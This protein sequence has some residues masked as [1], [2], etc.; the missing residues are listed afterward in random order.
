MSGVVASTAEHHRALTP[1]VAP[2]CEPQAQMQAWD[3]RGPWTP[4]GFVQRRIYSLSTWIYFLPHLRDRV[5]GVNPSK[6]KASWSCTILCFTARAITSH[7]EI[8]PWHCTASQSALAL[9]CTESEDNAWK[10]NHMEL[11]QPPYSFAVV[12]DIRKIKFPG[13]TKED[14]SFD[15]VVH[16]HLPW[17]DMSL[18]SC[19]ALS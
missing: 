6:Q 7:V 19:L 17:P 13:K 15:C 4:A 16:V 1:W 3:V 12:I 8:W 18:H 5:W 9:F 14:L 11:Q 10:K 2:M